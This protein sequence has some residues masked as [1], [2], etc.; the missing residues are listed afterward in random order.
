MILCTD[1]TMILLYSG[2]LSMPRNLAYLLSPARVAKVVWSVSL[3]SSSHRRSSAGNRIWNQVLQPIGNRYKLFWTWH[4]VLETSF[5][6]FTWKHCRMS[7]EEGGAP[8]TEELLLTLH[9]SQS[10]A[11]RRGTVWTFLPVVPQCCCLQV[12]CTGEGYKD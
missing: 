6:W 3:L 5:Q 11:Q 7:G 12:S 9:R 8:G 4:P 2:G 10:G 1:T